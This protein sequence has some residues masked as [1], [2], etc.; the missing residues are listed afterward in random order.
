MSSQDL[1]GASGTAKADMEEET[2][3][4]LSCD[5]DSAMNWVIGFR[6]WQ[7]ALKRED[8]RAHALREKTIE[9]SRAREEQ[10]DGFKARL[11]AER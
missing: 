8:G 10:L 9:L 6:M 5:I 7:E 11:L 2:K 1:F 4:W 3:S